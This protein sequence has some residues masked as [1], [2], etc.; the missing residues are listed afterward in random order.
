MFI[1]QGLFNSSEDMAALQTKDPAVS[2]TTIVD[3]YNE[4]TNNPAA[5]QAVADPNLNLH[6]SEVLAKTLK[7]SQ[8]LDILPLFYIMYVDCHGIDGETV[9]GKTTGVPF[10][11]ISFSETPKNP[12]TPDR[13]SDAN[14]HGAHK[15]N[16]VFLNGCKTADTNNG[17]VPVIGS[18]GSPVAG[19]PFTNQVKAMYT[20]FG[21]RAYVG[22]SDVVDYLKADKAGILF[23]QNLKPSTPSAPAITVDAA[24]QAT[25][26]D[27]S[28]SGYDSANLLDPIGGSE[29]AGSLGA[30]NGIITTG[31]SR[32]ELRLAIVSVVAPPS[33]TST[34]PAGLPEIRCQDGAR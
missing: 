17:S 23:F 25:M 6:G 29:T 5:V 24:I 13:V 3:E 9:Q 21:C 2:P 30:I 27:S 28:L 16:L 20:A 14:N 10:Q 33:T 7:A 31:P 1:G 18:N 15:Y 4:T 19:S 12:V 22:W 26:R 32:V 34:V 11:G 8:L